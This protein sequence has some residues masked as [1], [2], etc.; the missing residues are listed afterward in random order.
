MKL[1]LT[2]ASGFIG[3]AV[4]A[5]LMRDGHELVLVSRSPSKLEKQYGTLHT[6]YFWDALSVPPNKEV[7]EGVDGIINLMGEGVANKRWTKKQKQKISESRVKGTKNL[8]DG[9]KKY[10]KHLQVVVSASAIG[11]YD[12]FQDGTLDESSPASNSFLGQLCQNWENAAKTIPDDKPIRT[13]IFRIGVVLGH[14][15]GAMA[16]MIPPFSWG[17]GGKM[18]TGKQWM[19]WIHREDLAALIA[20]SIKNS[21]YSGTYNAV[22]PENIQNKAFTKLLGKLLQR[23]TFF[24]VPSFVIRLLLGEFSVEVLSGQKI[25]SN[26]VNKTG[27]VFK[28]PT[29]SQALEQVLS[30]KY[31]HHLGKKVRCD[32]FQCSQYLN[33]CPEQVFSFFSNAHNLEKIT[34]P[35]LKFGVASQSTKQIENGTIFNYKLKIR[36]L[37]IRWC[38]LITN[39]NPVKSFVDTQLKGPY[40]VWHHTHRFSAYLSGTLIED[41]VYYALPNLPFINTLFGWSV[42]RDIN[43]IFEFRKKEIDTIFQEKL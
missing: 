9:A 32:R 20:S 18:G 6:Y 5:K 37:P 33:H 8:M 1:L 14:G 41:E 19:N 11:F 34:P 24:H 4:I 13:V 7:F 36:G 28:Y 35:F 2:G 12:R 40:R 22:G 29:I 23:P 25:V 15:G 30:I 16:K 39:W 3:Q 21:D 26:R 17:L 31:I 10:A 43:N 38:S 27:F 42:R